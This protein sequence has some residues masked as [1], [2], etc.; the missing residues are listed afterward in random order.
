MSDILPFDSKI[1]NKDII[2]KAAVSVK[3]NICIA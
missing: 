1:D 2:D 3:Y